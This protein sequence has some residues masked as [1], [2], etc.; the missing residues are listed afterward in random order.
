MK[1]YEGVDVQI[2]VF[3]DLGTSWWVAS[4][5]LRPLYPLGKSPG[6]HWI[7][8]WVDPRPG[9]NDMDKWK[10]LTLPGLELRPIGRPASSQSLYRLR[11]PGSHKK[12]KKDRKYG[13]G[14]VE[15]EKRRE[16][17]RLWREHKWGERRKDN[18][19]KE[20]GKEKMAERMGRMRR[21]NI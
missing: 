13:R 17:E 16:E 18:K 11:Y 9:L 14:G 20:K 7:G 19:E 21:V 8:G 5:T 10:F 6:T 3:L 2:H 1:A 15:R 12:R 4:Y